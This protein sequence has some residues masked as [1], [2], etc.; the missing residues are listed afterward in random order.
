[1]RDSVVNAAAWMFSPSQPSLIP[2]TFLPTPGG[3]V[4]PLPTRRLQ[5]LSL[6][7]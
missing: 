5:A 3:D 4:D 1:M 7:H 6:P 2:K